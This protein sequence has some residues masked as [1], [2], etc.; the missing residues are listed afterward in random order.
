M[1]GGRSVGQIAMMVVWV[2]LVL[3]VVG[4][5]AGAYVP[6]RRRGARRP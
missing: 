6:L 1:D 2:I 3:V 5:G 4:G